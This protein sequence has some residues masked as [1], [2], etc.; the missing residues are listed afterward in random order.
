M[1]TAA[2]AGA[3]ALPAGWLRIAGT[4]V[5][6]VAAATP[7]LPATVR[8][9]DG[10]EVTVTDSRRTIAGGDSVIAVMEALGLAGHVYAAPTDSATAAGRAAPKQF[11]FNRGTGVEGVLSLDATLFIGNSMRRHADGGLVGKLRGAG[12]PALVYDDLQPA[13]DKIRGIAAALGLADA[14]DALATQVQVQLDRAAEAGARLPRKARILH[15]SATGAGGQPTVAGR[16]NAGSILVR[17]AG[18]DNV[19]DATG[20]RDYDPLSSE[21]IVASD[22]EIVL[23]SEHDLRVFGGR[24]GLYAAYP[25]LEHTRAGLADRVW[26]MP[27]LQLKSL[28]VGS[29][30]GAL[31]LADALA[32]YV[33]E[34]PPRDG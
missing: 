3:P 6:Q 25:G 14:G 11:R 28:T 24:E 4:G 7:R 21:G 29:G 9:N 16:D 12:M 27:D 19:G 22:P 2:E 17:L 32:A 5:P 18:G 31:A 23:L 8:S 15:V 26:V 34:H 20:V 13:P 1:D 30:A 33:A 10:V